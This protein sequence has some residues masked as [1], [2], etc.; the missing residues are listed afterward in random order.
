MRKRTRNPCRDPRCPELRPCPL[1]DAD[2]RVYDTERWRRASHAYLV[3]HPDC[4]FALGC[5]RPSAQTNH[6]V[7]V[8]ELLE[9]GL[10]P[11]DAENF[12]ALCHHHHGAR[13]RHEYA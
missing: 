11:Y 9:R 2:P 1:H 5:T 3:A 10:D 13:T 8:R 12:E 6:R 4:E 7:P